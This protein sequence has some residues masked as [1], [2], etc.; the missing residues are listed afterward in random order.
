[1]K[2]GKMMEVLQTH[3][4]EMMMLKVA[5]VDAGT[6]SFLLLIAEKSNDHLKYLL[7]TSTVVGLGHLKNG[8][9]DAK[10]LKNAQEVINA[11]HKLCN[12]YEVDKRVIVGTEFFR[13]IDAKYFEHL[14]KNFDESMILSGLEEAKLSY[15]SV[16]EDERFSS[17]PNPVVVDIGGG[18]VEFAYRNEKFTTQSFSIGA[19]VLT[20]QFVKSYPIKNQLSGAIDLLNKTFEGIANGDLVAIGGTGTTLV[21]LIDE[22]KFNPNRVHGRFLKIEEIESLYD[23]LCSINL[24][25]LSKA[26]GMEK[27]R[28]RIIAAGALILMQAVK[29]INMNGCF[30]SIRGHRYTIAKDILEQKS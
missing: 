27:G 26:Q 15:L 9:I 28:E 20:N 24:Y 2:A 19:M 10:I 23:K 22:K 12:E 7:D 11:Y 16:I 8:S 13:N 17:L 18:S 1:M 25:D 6:N 29:K 30:V 4:K 3:N 21:N 14:S 5:I